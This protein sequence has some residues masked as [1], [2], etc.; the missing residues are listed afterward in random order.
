M[1]RLY[2]SMAG[3]LLAILM[4]GAQSDIVSAETKITDMKPADLCTRKLPH[5]K[6][7]IDQ[8]RL[9]TKLYYGIV[10]EPFFD[11]GE[12]NRNGG[13]IEVREIDEYLIEYSGA[14]SDF[15]QGD[16]GNFTIARVPARYE[17]SLPQDRARIILESPPEQV[18]IVCNGYAPTSEPKV[19]GKKPGK[20]T[21][22]GELRVRLD[23]TTLPTKLTPKSAKGTG[24]KPARSEEHT[25]E[26]V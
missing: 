6:F 10:G 3:S 12:L 25:S 16:T 1:K 26:R 23:I 14:L 15:V 4:L 9:R 7:A 18:I 20:G 5:N 24:L 11:P 21:G 19:A 8:E 17:G 2:P 13:S 22:T